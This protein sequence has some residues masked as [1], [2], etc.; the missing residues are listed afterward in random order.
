M[1]TNLIKLTPL[2]EEFQDPDCENVGT[3][4]DHFGVFTVVNKDDSIGP[5]N[6]FFY[7]YLYTI[8]SENTNAKFLN[9]ITYA[10]VPLEYFRHTS[11]SEEQ[12]EKE[13]KSWLLFLK[14]CG[15]HFT[16]HGVQ[17]RS[18]FESLKYPELCKG[19][20]RSSSYTIGDYDLDDEE[21]LWSKAGFMDPR[22]CLIV[23][24]NHNDLKDDY[25][26]LLHF[27]L[28]RYFH[29]WRSR[30][31]AERAMECYLFGSIRRVSAYQCLLTAHLEMPENGYYALMEKGIY[32]LKRATPGFGYLKS[33]TVNGKHSVYLLEERPSRIN[34][35]ELQK[36]LHNALAKGTM[37]Q[38]FDFY[39]LDFNGTN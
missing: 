9:G 4:L 22:K 11:M 16:Y 33:T 6:E 35:F 19:L 21:D 30:I 7:H 8:C 17:K 14:L 2:W 32:D 23:S 27:S 36:L 3:G 24:Y 10:Y 29:S 34:R 38:K 5:V 15:F 31:V 28:I 18:D 25:D 39:N 1:K 13:F 20:K 37:Y 26:G 12:I